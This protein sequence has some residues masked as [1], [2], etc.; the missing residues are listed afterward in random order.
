MM[1]FIRI[2]THPPTGNGYIK[3]NSANELC[4]S[5][6]KNTYAP[7]P[8]RINYGIC[9]R[10]GAYLPASGMSE[11]KNGLTPHVGTVFMSNK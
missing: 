1:C 8:I 4:L 7:I 5:V 11:R 2:L 10:G 9:R 6:E 3:N